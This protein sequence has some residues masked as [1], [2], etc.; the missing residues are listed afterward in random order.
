[1]RNKLSNQSMILDVAINDLD[2]FVRQRAMEKLTDQSVPVEIALGDKISSEDAILLISD[3]DALATIAHQ[4]KNT[5]VKRMAFK[6][7]G[8]YICTL[9]GAENWPDNGHTISCICSQCKAENHDFIHIDNVI[10][11]RDYESGSRWDECTRCGLTIRNQN[12]IVCLI[13]TM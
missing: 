7:L 8:G 6:K 2:S 13:L 12:L 11:H 1:L 4:A 5:K 9:C 3:K 10:D